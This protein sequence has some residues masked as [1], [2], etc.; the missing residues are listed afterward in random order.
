MAAR[1]L[2]LAEGLEGELATLHSK[3][4]QGRLEQLFELETRLRTEILSTKEELLSH[5]EGELGA[6]Q[7]QLAGFARSSACEAVA[8]RVEECRD[9]LGFRG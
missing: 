7:P 4:A 2:E 8:S 9:F 3:L 1:Q 6:L 5:F